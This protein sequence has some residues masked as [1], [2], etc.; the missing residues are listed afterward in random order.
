V[1]A[2]CQCKPSP[3]H[4]S[5]QQL[6]CISTLYTISTS[7]RSSSAYNRTTTKGNTAIISR[8]C[9]THCVYQNKKTTML[10]QVEKM[11]NL[12][13]ASHLTIIISN[14]AIQNSVNFPISLST[15]YFLK[16]QLRRIDNYT[17]NICNNN[18]NNTNNEYILSD[19]CRLSRTNE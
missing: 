4:R 10:Y 8:D 17:S 16:T 19:T 1:V 2:P 11:T 12:N 9:R 14:D 13:F 7:S 5:P 15:I 6:N 3:I 18:N